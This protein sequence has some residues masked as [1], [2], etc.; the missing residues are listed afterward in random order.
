[1]KGE[2]GILY[3]DSAAAAQKSRQP[4]SYRHSINLLRRISELVS[5]EGVISGHGDGSSSL[6]NRNASHRNTLLAAG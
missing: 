2:S 5:A 4:S 6:I 3:D 1:M